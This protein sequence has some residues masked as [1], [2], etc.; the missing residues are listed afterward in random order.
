MSKTTGFYPR[1][2]V[3][4]TNSGAVGQAGGVLLIETIAAAGLG[5]AMSAALSGWRKPLAVHD[6]AKV[7]VD[8]LP[9]LI[10]KTCMVIADRLVRLS[11]PFRDFFHR[12][13][14]RTVDQDRA[15]PRLPN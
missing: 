5:S 10:R 2:Q 8:K 3:D 15:F 7:V 13:A 4:T 12:P 6:P 1:I 11:Q 9:L 14:R